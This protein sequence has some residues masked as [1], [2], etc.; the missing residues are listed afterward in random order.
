LT[1]SSAAL[2]LCRPAAPP[3]SA[4]TA[5]GG[6]QQKSKANISGSVQSANPSIRFHFASER[7]IITSERGLQNNRKLPP[8]PNPKNL[9]MD[10]LF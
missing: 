5:P 6:N 10:Y 7:G 4:T 1:A 2:A 8:I 9:T 3:P